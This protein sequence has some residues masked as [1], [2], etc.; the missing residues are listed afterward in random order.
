MASYQD[1]LSSGPPSQPLEFPA[2]IFS[3]VTRVNA[4]VYNPDTNEEI[5]VPN[6]FYEV[7]SDGRA[8]SRA[9]WVGRKLKKA[10]YGCV[11]SCTVL[12]VREGG[13][14]G[15]HGNSIWELT[16]VLAAVKIIDLNKVRDLKGK[17]KEDPMKEVAAMQF[18]STDGGVPNVL[19]CWDLFRDEKYIYMCM[20]YCSSG[21]LFGYV[22]RSGRFEEPIARYWFKQLL[23]ALIGL[24]KRGICHRDISLENILIHEN[25]HAL[26][27]DLGMCLRVPYA[28]PLG[29]NIVCDSTAG[30]LRMPFVPQGQCGKPNYI[31]PE[32]LTN[33]VPFDGFAVDLWAAGVV[34]FIMLVGLPPF[35]W[36]SFDDPRYRLICEGGL[37][38]LLVQWKRPISHLAIDLIQ[39]M[40]REHPQERLS[41]FQVMN[42]PWVLQ[43]TPFPLEALERLNSTD[44]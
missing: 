5:I 2:P 29:C 25:T 7:H 1:V 42:H 34:L 26:V 23:N 24:Q 21:E 9:Y 11:C 30:T 4:F 33:N 44:S 31:S 20:P 32:V 13:W 8:P 43:Q 18:L 6:I 15:P 39:S 19:P 41:L 17:H 14:A 40:L 27:I 37:E 12:K 28:S 35:E 16:S 3:E 22:Q 36:A 38:Q 10:I